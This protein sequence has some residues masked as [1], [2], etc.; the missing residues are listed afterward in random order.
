MIT[1]YQNGFKVGST[2]PSLPGCE[3]KLMHEEGRDK[4]GNGEICYRGRH[5]MMGYMKMEEKTRGA[6]DEEGWL[7]SGD[8]G[9]VDEKG[10]LYITGRIKELLITAGGENIAPVPIED[11]IKSRIPAVSNFMMVGDKRKYN[12]ALVTLK[13]EPNED[14][15]FSDKLAG[16]ATSVSSATTVGE[17]KSDEAWQKYIMDAITAYNNSDILVSRAQKIQ[18]FVILDRDFSVP[19]GELGPTLKLKRGTVMEHFEKE[20]EGLYSE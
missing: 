13:T 16:E 6:I 12:V 15:T 18:K 8:V 4:P 19:E 20:I 1:P 7:H 3:M 5:I 11:F 14:G 2:G 9:R 17:A 10:L